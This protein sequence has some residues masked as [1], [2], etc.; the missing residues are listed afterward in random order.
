MQQESI[1]AKWKIRNKYSHRHIY[2][3]NLPGISTG[4]Q[5]FVLKFEKCSMH[6]KK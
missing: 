4:D 6:L 1:N 2:I 3:F 5:D